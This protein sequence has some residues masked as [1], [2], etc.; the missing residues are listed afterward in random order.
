MA[1]RMPIGDRLQLLSDAT[2]LI[3]EQSAP[4]T[5][6]TLVRH[7]RITPMEAHRVLTALRERGIVGGSPLTLL[8]HD[9]RQV[10]ALLR[11]EHASEAANAVN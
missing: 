8:R 6:A 11:S 10:L 4:P 7:L 2:V 3:S 1:E 9:T 5:Q